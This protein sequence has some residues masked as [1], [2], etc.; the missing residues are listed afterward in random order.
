MPLTSNSDLYGAVHE[1]GINKI[2]KHIMRQRPSLF[3]YGTALVK[4]NP[5]LLCSRIDAAPAVTELITLLPRLPLFPSGA[6]DLSSLSEYGIDLSLETNLALDYAVQLAEMQVDFH[7]SNVF[8]LPPELGPPLDPQQL[9]F[10]AKVCGGLSCIPKSVLKKFP[11]K[12]GAKMV[13]FAGKGQLKRTQGLSLSKYAGR[14]LSVRAPAASTKANVAVSA[15]QP[16]LILPGNLRPF[17]PIFPVDKLE[18]FCMELFATAKGEFE[19][20]AGNQRLDLGIDGIELKDLAPEG[21][22]KSIECYMRILMDRVILPQVSDAVSELIFRMQEIPALT[23]GDPSMGSIQISAAT[24]PA[25][26]P[27][28]EENQLKVFLNLEELSVTIPPIVISSDGGPPVPTRIERARTST[29]PA[30]ITAAVSEA[31]FRRIFGIIRDT[32][33][34]KIKVAPRTM[35]M[36]GVTGTASA[37]VEFHLENGTVSFEPDNTIRISELDIKWDKLEV[38]IGLNLPTMCFTIYVP[39]PVPPFVVPVDLGCIFEANPDLQFTLSL[40]TGFTTEVSCNA[41]L[42][43]YYGIGTPNEWMVYIT[44]SRVDLD[45][46]DVADTVGDMLENALN[47]V[48]GALG[49]PDAIVDVIG[50]IIDLVR[51]VLDIA[52]DLGEWLQNLI[53]D[54]LGIESTIESYIAIWMADTMPIFRLEDPVEVMPTEGSLIAVKLPIEYLGAQVNDSE[55]VLMVDVGG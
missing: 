31:A 28:V 20:Q 9:A 42:K 29:G 6:I 21:L 14:A 1:D 38:T 5:N 44:P 46:I 13:R 53:F 16:G 35:S 17:V 48:A 19:G 26:N 55:M 24:A 49:I 40:P 33:R 34:F 36:F 47:A 50:S 18:C 52:D 22:E 8:T 2:I 45:I 11:P 3:N 30:H 7:P 51:E 12:F 43:T 25:H 54:A 32:G 10:R 4:A 37:E 39:I 41:G 15:L 27:A 23:E